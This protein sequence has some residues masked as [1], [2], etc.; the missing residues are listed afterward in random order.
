MKDKQAQQQHGCVGSA[1]PRRYLWDQIRGVCTFNIALIK[2]LCYRLNEKKSHR[3]A[4]SRELQKFRQGKTWSEWG[5]TNASMFLTW[6]AVVLRSRNY[7]NLQ[8]IFDPWRAVVN[9]PSESSSSSS[10]S[11]SRTSAGRVIP[12]AG[13]ESNIIVSNP[14]EVLSAIVVQ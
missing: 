12:T 1:V 4:K 9:L 14:V 6:R 5:S 10:A 11:F 7:Y 2:T 8:E 13:V 3:L